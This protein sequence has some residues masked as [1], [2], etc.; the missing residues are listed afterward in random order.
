M[1]VTLITN[2][3]LA[4]EKYASSLTVRYD[5]G[6][7]YLQVLLQARDAVHLGQRLLTAPLAGSIKPHQT[8]YRSV[9]LAAHNPSGSHA[10]DVQLIEGAIEVYHKQM[11]G[12]RRQQWP[13]QVKGDFAT[14]DLSLI[15]GAL[16]SV[17]QR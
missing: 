1:G 14:V 8:P 2:N 5:G 17:I 10:G 12:K 15:D 9:L 13:E 16:N 7:D 3:P 6:W 4:A 11:Q